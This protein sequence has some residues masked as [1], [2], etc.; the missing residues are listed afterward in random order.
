MSTKKWPKWAKMPSIGKRGKN[1]KKMMKKN[2]V[3]NFLLK[4]NAL[5]FHPPHYAR[6]K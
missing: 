1:G 5:I 6:K 2:Y 3:P 4:I